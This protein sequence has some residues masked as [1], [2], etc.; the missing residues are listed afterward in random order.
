MLIRCALAAIDH[1]SNTDREQ[2]TTSGGLPRFD[3]VKQKHGKK[4]QVRAIKEAK[5]TSWRQCM[6]SLLLKVK[7]IIPI[8]SFKKF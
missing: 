6:A 4:H 5:D 2:A 8:F 1:N 7:L 3:F